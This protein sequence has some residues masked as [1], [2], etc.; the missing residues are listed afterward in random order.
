MKSFL[1]AEIVAYH[2]TRHC[3]VNLENH[4]SKSDATPPFHAW[5]RGSAKCNNL[6]P[7]KKQN[8]VNCNQQKKWNKNAIKAK[9][10]GLQGRRNLLSLDITWSC[11]SSNYILV[12]ISGLLTHLYCNYMIY[13]FEPCNSKKI[14]FARTAACWSC[15]PLP[16]NSSWSCVHCSWCCSEHRGCRAW[17]RFHQNFSPRGRGGI[18]LLRALSKKCDLDRVYFLHVDQSASS[19]L[20]TVFPLRQSSRY[21][22]TPLQSARQR[23]QSSR[24]RCRM[25]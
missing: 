18:L 20:L 7:Y 9:F 24:P 5:K 11:V 2:P 10:W 19:L 3:F 22:E 13:M 25:A 8:H 6:L 1:V 17:V 23:S 4:V 15:P 14:T 21:I 12:L 16:P